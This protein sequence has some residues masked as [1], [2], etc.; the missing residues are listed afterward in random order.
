CCQAVVQPDVS[1]IIL[2]DG[3]LADQGL[4]SRFLITTPDSAAG[5]RLWHEP[6]PESGA[7]LKR[8]GARLL[9][10]LEQP[11]PLATGKSNELEPR[12]L[13]LSAGVRGLWISFADHIEAAIGP[14]SALEPCV[15]WQTSCLSTL[16][17]L[18]QSWWWWTI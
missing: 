3:L 2:N 17:A 5:L 9:D 16:H 18:P 4:H 12:R 7:A 14:N 11:L 6:K 1:G 13:T 8:Y 10:I 15:V